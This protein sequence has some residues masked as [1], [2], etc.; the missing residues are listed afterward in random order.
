METRYF[1]T[2]EEC[3]E[4]RH[5]GNKILLQDSVYCNET[6]KIKV[7]HSLVAFGD[8][9]SMWVF[10]RGG[11]KNS[12]QW[13]SCYKNPMIRESLSAESLMKH[14]CKSYF[15]TEHKRIASIV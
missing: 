2:L 11:G 7:H 14:L 13:Y 1:D 4:F 3:K 6:G 10:L 15:K 8:K 12:G 5:F 9:Y